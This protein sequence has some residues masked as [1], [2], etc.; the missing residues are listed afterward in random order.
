[1]FPGVKIKKDKAPGVDGV[2]WRKYEE[3]LDENIEDLVARLIAKQYRPQPVKRAYVPKSNG[4]RR[5]LGMHDGMLE[6]TCSRPKFA[7]N[8]RPVL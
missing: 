7:A 6:T 5:P 8:N 2:T 1:M 3:N 4:E